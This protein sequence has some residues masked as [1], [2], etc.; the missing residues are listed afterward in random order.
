MGFVSLML[1]KTRNGTTIWNLF[2]EHCAIYT[3]TQTAHGQTNILHVVTK[4]HKQN[5]YIFFFFVETKWSKPSVKKRNSETRLLFPD[6]SAHVVRFSGRPSHINRARRE[7]YI[8][9]AIRCLN[10]R[11][12]SNYHGYSRYKK[13]VC[14]RV[15]LPCYLRVFPTCHIRNVSHQQCRQ[16][17]TQY[18]APNYWCC[19]FLPVRRGWRNIPTRLTHTASF[20]CCSGTSCIYPKP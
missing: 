1:F 5:L 15:I 6:H 17:C 19:P 11:H 14:W 20:T 10:F 7:K 16:C 3:P 4:Q 13:I 2:M 8:F 18:S 12:P 9:K